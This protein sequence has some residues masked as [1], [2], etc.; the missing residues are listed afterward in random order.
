[1]TD[2]YARIAGTYDALCTLGS[3]GAVARCK[4]DA[5]RVVRPGDRVL[6]AGAGT[7]EEAVLAAQTGAHV[8][9][10][11]LSPAMLARATARARKAGA[12][13]VAI[14]G[15]ILAHDAAPYDVVVANFFLNVFEPAD[16]RR[17]LAKLTALTRPT[18]RLVIGDVIL[19]GN[20]V[21]RT[22]TRLYWNGAILLFRILTRNAAHPVYDYETEL[23]SAG[24]VVVDRRIRGWF[25]SL[26]A[27]R[28]A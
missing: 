14:R 3:L 8:T 11:D 13:V 26:A 25:G 27:I 1:M 6:F 10:V 15:D 12:S 5:L 16:M 19:P 17:V 24:F 28:E 20:P 2:R 7:G 23:R 4:R 9:I 21:Y 22:L 18:G